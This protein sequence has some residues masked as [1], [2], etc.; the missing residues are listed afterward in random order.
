VSA[1]TEQRALL[2]LSADE[3]GRASHFPVRPRLLKVKSAMKG[4][5]RALI[6][7]ERADEL[8][9]A[10]PKD[11]SESV[12]ALLS[13]EFILGDV[14]DRVR[15]LH[16]NPRALWIATLSVGLP[17]VATLRAACDAG[18]QVT[19][20]VSHYFQSADAELYEAI[21]RAM[22]DAPGFRLIVGRLHCKVL[23]FEFDSWLLTLTT[24]ANLRSSNNLEQL[25]G[26]AAPALFF[27]HRAWMQ[28][29]C[30]RAES[31]A[32]PSHYVLFAKGGCN[33]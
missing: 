30:D 16:G 29:V 14:I 9:R 24:S 28:E 11:E 31:G 7:A 27:F 19:L 12:H 17:N 10:L 4:Q 5:A 23:L 13:G 2:M 15:A 33:V 20:L 32:N 21:E 18:V 3:S 25:D 1:L 22:A 8:V 6:R 26:F